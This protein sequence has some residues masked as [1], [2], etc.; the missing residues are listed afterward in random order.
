[1]LLSL[2]A[3]LHRIVRREGVVMK[4][5][6]EENTGNRIIFLTVV[7][8]M[9]LCFGL[10]L[11]RPSGIVSGLW[12]IV[13]E[14]DYLI[15]DYFVIGG[16]GAAFVN[17]GLL[18]LA[19]T[20]LLGTIRTEIRGLSLAAVFTIAGF[21]FFGK[22]IAN[23]WFVVAGVWLYAQVQRRPFVRFLYV[24]LF[25]TALSP[26]VSQ[27]MFGLEGPLVCRVIAGGAVGV[28]MGFLL[29]PLSTAML[30]FHKGFNLYNIGFTAGLVG[31][32]AISIYRSFGFI[33]QSRVIWHRGI[34]P[35]I[36]AFLGALFA[37]IL[38]AGYVAGGKSFR[39]IREIWGYPGR[40]LTDFP[41]LSGYAP[42]LMN[43]GLN[44]LVFL[45]YLVAIGG[46]L[47]GPT[48]GGLLTVVGF[49]ALGKTT[50][51][52]LPVLFGVV[53][54]GL[55][56]SWSLQDPPVQLAALFCTTLAPVAGSFGPLAGVAA[57]YLHSSVV[58]HVGILHAGFNL[59][60]N[61]FAGGLV[62]A[63]LVP[64]I[65]AFSGRKDA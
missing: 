1:M 12:N 42:T 6:A 7:S 38:L 63:F 33:P 23:V 20:V 58:L 35:L 41:D 32:V 5:L 18:M 13:R 19:F 49:S 44:G 51:N 65:E 61:G 45:S 52:T 46:D 9:F 40:L 55:T 8:V 60:N 21:S 39:G 3:S 34:D 24:A 16:P 25:G 31:T 22:N 54:G 10:L 29:P 4:R 28:A 47:N 57:G 30:S 59:Y 36:L 50:R 43:M 17:S 15:S 48:I 56:K 64:L 62:A 11:D 53:L 37:G 14:P 27:I 26:M 2:R